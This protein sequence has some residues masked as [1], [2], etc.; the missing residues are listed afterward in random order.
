MSEEYNI[1]GR[2][3]ELGNIPINVR[4]SNDIPKD[5]FIL[6]NGIQSSLIEYNNVIEVKMIDEKSGVPINISGAGTGYSRHLIAQLMRSLANDIE[7][8][9][10]LNQST[11]DKVFEGILRAK[12]KPSE[13]S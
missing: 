2:I 5:F 13:L 11:I 9:K 12:K 6:T 3:E 7:T 10:E 8:G 4:I 1:V